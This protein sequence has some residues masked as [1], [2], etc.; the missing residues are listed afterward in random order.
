[1]V[2]SPV[3]FS[4]PSDMG[5]SRDLLQEKLHTRLTFKQSD[6]TESFLAV[7]SS[8]RDVG[9]AVDPQELMLTAGMRSAPRP[10]WERFWRLP[11][12]CS[13]GPGGNM[14]ANSG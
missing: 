2:W 10:S 14:P 1:M 9:M 7:D 5:F 11:W 4:L 12:S 13:G 6:K 3:L 8:P